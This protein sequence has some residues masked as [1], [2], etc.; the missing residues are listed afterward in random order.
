MIKE[1]AAA[2]I[3]ARCYPEICLSELRS[4]MKYLRQDNR[5]PVLDLNS[6]FPEYETR[7]GSTYLAVMVDSVESA[8]AVP[9]ECLCVCV[10]GGEI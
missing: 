5:A 1:V 6:G 3:W 8:K 2:E 7:L 4:A 10:G 9:S